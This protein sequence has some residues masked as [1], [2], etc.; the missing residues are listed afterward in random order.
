MLSLLAKATLGGSLVPTP[1][2]FAALFG[3][4]RV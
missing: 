3:S 2:V 1:A 4:F